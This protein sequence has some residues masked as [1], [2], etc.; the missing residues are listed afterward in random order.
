MHKSIKHLPL[1]ETTFY[2][3]MVLHSPLHGYAIMQKVESISKGKVKIA[4]GT[5][6][7]AIEH[8]L[9]LKWIK[10]VPSNDK[11]RKVYLITELGKEIFQLETNRMKEL[12]ALVKK[13][14]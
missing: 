7:G 4:A 11:R 13:I 8:L 14:N 10:S 3:M 2:I 1:T 6:Y 12:I 5:M 9:S